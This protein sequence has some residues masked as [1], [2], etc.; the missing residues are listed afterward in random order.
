[1]KVYQD[2]YL[3][4]WGD[5]YLSNKAILKERGV[6]FDTFLIDPKAILE[7]VLFGKPLPLPEGE[8]FYPLLPSQRA[9][10][11]RLINAELD[12]WLRDELERELTSVRL[13]G[14]TPV[15]CADGQIIEPLK[16]HAHPQRRGNR[17]KFWPTQCG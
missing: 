9:V 15:R 2:Q 13:T 4:Y 8:D 11:E 16:H 5:V 17:C 7:A 6:L 1:M 3:E 12:E 10:Q 14:M